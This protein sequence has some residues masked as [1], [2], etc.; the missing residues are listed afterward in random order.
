MEAQSS[1]ADLDR[2]VD[3]LI[4]EYRDRC[5]WFLRRDFRPVSR[6]ER[7]RALEYIER[8]GDLEAHRRAGRLKRWLSQRSNAPSAT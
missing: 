1:D 6:E 7:L 5:L 3:E 4:D 8:H 2:A